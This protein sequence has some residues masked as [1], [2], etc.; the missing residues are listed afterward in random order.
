MSYLASARTA[1]TRTARS[2]QL[3]PLLWGLTN[4]GATAVRLCVCVFVGIAGLNK[5]GH[6]ALE[7]GAGELDR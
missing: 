5:P 3:P 4:K 2:R 1:A 6:V 7:R